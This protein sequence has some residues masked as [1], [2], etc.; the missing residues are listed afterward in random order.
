VDARGNFSFED[1]R[2]LRSV[3]VF[4]IVTFPRTAVYR[5]SN[6]F[7]ME[8]N[9]KW[10]KGKLPRCNRRINPTISFFSIPLARIQLVI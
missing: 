1:R 5:K 4:P 2:R 10:I 9:E 3:R 6:F 7:E 8:K